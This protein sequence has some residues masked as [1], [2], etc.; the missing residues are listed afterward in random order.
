MWIGWNLSWRFFL[1]TVKVLKDGKIINQNPKAYAIPVV[2][3][4][5]EKTYAYIG[6][7]INRGG[8]TK[9]LEFSWHGAAEYQKKFTPDRPVYTPTMSGLFVVSFLF[10]DGCLGGL[11]AVLK[12]TWEYF[13]KYVPT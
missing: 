8:F 12:S 2:D 3:I 5:E 11:F 9:T 10:F 4:I 13:G 1:C 7:P 6:V